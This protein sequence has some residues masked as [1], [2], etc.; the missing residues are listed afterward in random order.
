MPGALEPVGSPLLIGAVSSQAVNV[1]AIAAAIA[2]Q[3]IVLNFFMSVPP[4][5]SVNSFIWLC[6]A[7]VIVFI[8]SKFSPFFNR[9][10]LS[11]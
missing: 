1:S 11:I 2:A 9:Q 7:N 4:S 3:A 5:V 10:I 6:R 8:I